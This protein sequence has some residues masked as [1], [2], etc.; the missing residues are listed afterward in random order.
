V[1]VIDTGRIN[2][3]IP[4]GLPK[5]SAD[6]D[7]LERILVN[8]ASNAIKYSSPESDVLIRAESN[9][10]EVIVSIADRGIGVHPEDISHLF[11]RFYR[12]KGARKA[13][14]LGLG[15]FITRLLV[16]AHGGRL[17]VESELGKGSV[18]YFTLPLAS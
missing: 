10:A 18:F 4:E 7:R 13:E 14:G 1:G 9:D 16:E 11:E 15:L 5:V 8:L 17:W 3:E 6:P 12:A 2:V